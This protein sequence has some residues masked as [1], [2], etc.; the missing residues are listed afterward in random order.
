MAKQ[1]KTPKKKPSKAL[2]EIAALMPVKRLLKGGVIETLPGRFTKVYTLDMAQDITS[3]L[4]GNTSRCSI[5]LFAMS[6]P[7]SKLLSARWRKLTISIISRRSCTK[8]RIT[9]FCR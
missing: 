1:N 3:V 5:E 4:K 2:K 6:K 7:K 9:W 8:P